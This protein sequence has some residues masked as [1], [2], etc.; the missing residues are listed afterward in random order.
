MLLLQKMYAL[1][2]R[3]A[4]ALALRVGFYLD[5][6]F[7]HGFDPYLYH[8]TLLQM[9]AAGGIVGFLAYLSHRIHTVVLFFKRPTT[10][11]L[12]IAI[13]LI[14]FLGFNLLD[15]LFFKF[16]P[17]FFYSFMLLCAEK[18]EDTPK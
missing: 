2:L 1:I 6:A 13:S 8:N 16:Y 9:L 12:F 11:N 10:A 14:A 5:P 3:E 7:E 15:V 17:A 18:S 4:A